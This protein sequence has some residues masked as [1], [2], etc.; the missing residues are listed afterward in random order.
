[1][2]IFLHM[3]EYRA[4]EDQNPLTVSQL[5]VEIWIG[6]VNVQVIRGLDGPK[7]NL[8]LVIFVGRSMSIISTSSLSL[9]NEQY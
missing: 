4:F 1:M 6:L 2:F 5:K 8:V 7:L 9:K 3:V